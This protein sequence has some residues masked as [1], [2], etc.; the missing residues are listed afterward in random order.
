M[1]EDSSTAEAGTE[2][3]VLDGVWLRRE[4]ERIA[5]GRR[6]VAVRLGL[7]ESRVIRVEMNRLPVPADW[8][9]ALAALG[10]PVPPEVLPVATG[11]ETAG[12]AAPA[13]PPAPEVLPSVDPP[14]VAAEPDVPV[15][16]SP[17]VSAPPSQLLTKAALPSTTTLDTAP[18]SVAE[19]IAAVPEPAAS[20]ST[21]IIEPVPAPIA[22][23]VPAAIAEPV[24]APIAAPVPVAIA[25][26]VPAPIAEPVPAAIVP[27]VTE[28]SVMA[29]EPPMVTRAEPLSA[30]SPAPIE[31]GT[32]YT[33]HWLRRERKKRGMM[34]IAIAPALHVTAAELASA[35]A[36]DSP[37][38]LHWLPSLRQLGLPVSE[39]AAA[40]AAQ[41]TPSPQVT[42]PPA[43]KPTAPR[44][45]KATRTASAAAT[46]D[47][48][49]ESNLPTGAWLRQHRL[50]RNIMQRELSARLKT[51]PSELCRYEM[52]DRPL[53][54][55]W[56]PILRELGFPLPTAANDRSPPRGP[57]SVNESEKPPAQSTTREMASTVIDGRWLKS[58]RTRLGLSLHAVRLHLHVSAKTYARFEASR[59]LVP[60]FWWPGLRQIGM[61]LPAAPPALPSKPKPHTGPLNGAWLVR[62]RKRLR[63]TQ[64][65]VCRVL[66]ANPRMIHRIERDA[67]ELPKAWLA[68]L[69]LLGIAVDAAAQ[70]GLARST[71]SRTKSAP[72]TPPPG[73]QPTGT[74]NP[75]APETIKPASSAPATRQG[76]DLV[77]LIVNFR[78]TL[79]QHT[80][81]PPF[82]ILSRILSDLREAGADQALTRE[83]VERAARALIPKRSAG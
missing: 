68:K 40:L 15:T 42:S 81:Q 10:F 50:Q 18:E 5:I 39:A 22:A 11:A 55:D 52:E 61:R 30:P 83:D 32:I 66:Q 70:R 64:Y 56:L 54:P 41:S 31:A 48:N 9:P 24:P 14:P 73:Q 2:E 44:K 69:P 4:R 72:R 77:A 51:N 3:P 71:S 76:A 79:G 17:V 43:S 26:P 53:R 35:E 13:N 6:Q 59:G 47:S 75:V 37:L 25:E 23:P 80:K 8:L 1:R 45:T 57:A 16:V 38:P 49:P 46:A 19:P 36:Q 33:G 34:P 58:E 78:L 21:P 67:V 82:E 65:E 60:R 62:E 29:A 12:P 7:P 63:L 27:S 74:A 28:E 20:S